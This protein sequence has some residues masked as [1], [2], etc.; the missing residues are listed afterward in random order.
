MEKE[1]K[2]SKTQKINQ[3]QKKVI[4]NIMINKLEYIYLS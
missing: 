4:D 1:E 2:Q 3:Q